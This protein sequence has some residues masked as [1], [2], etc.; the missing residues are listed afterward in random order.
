MEVYTTTFTLRNA[1]VD[2]YR[3]LRPSV[4]LTA[5]QR[6]VFSKQLPVAMMFMAS[7]Y[8]AQV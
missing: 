4:L 7:S 3:R 8:M 6:S 5:M 1:D 2:Q